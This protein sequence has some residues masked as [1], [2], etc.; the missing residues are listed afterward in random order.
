MIRNDHPFSVYFPEDKCIMATEV[1]NSSFK[2]P[3]ANYKVMVAAD[4]FHL[5]DI[6]IK[7]AH[8]GSIGI[9]SFIIG[10]GIVEPISNPRFAD[11]HQGIIFPV[12]THKI[13]QVAG[14]PVFSLFLQNFPDL[15][16]IGLRKEG[17]SQEYRKKQ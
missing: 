9:G 2:H 7:F 4:L 17:C 6:K 3:F 13:V 8:T 10:Q 5:N 1:T 11:E 16:F 15:R 12:T 14:V